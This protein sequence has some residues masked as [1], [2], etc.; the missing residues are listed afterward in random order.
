MPLRV[1][2]REEEQPP[3]GG[4]S[5]W[6]CF[7]EKA[8]QRVFFSVLLHVLEFFMSVWHYYYSRN[9]LECPYYCLDQCFKMESRNP[10]IGYT[11]TFINRDQHFFKKEIEN[12]NSALY[13]VR[14]Y[15]FVKLLFDVI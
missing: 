3:T 7:L 4:N 15:C 12:V 9:S 11:I 1:E 14:T 6:M 2:S 13:E 10:L 8:A 5:L